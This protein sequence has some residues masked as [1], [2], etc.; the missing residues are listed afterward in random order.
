MARKLG[1]ILQDKVL[2]IAEEIRKEAIYAPLEGERVG[3]VFPVYGW[4]PPRIVL[5]F[6]RK[7]QMQVL[8]RFPAHRADTRCDQK[9]ESVPYLFC[10]LCS[11]KLSNL[12]LIG[13]GSGSTKTADRECGNASCIS[14][15]LGQG[16]TLGQALADT[17]DKAVAGAGGIHSLD[18]ECGHML[19]NAV[20]TVDTTLYTKGDD[21]VLHTQIVHLQDG[22]LGVFDGVQLHAEDQLCLGLIGDHD[23]CISAQLFGGLGIDAVQLERNSSWGSAFDAF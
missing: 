19:C 23:I 10:F 4:E 5:D 7:M 15:A 1:D 14:K 11:D 22:V 21:G 6:I 18:N 3:F 20:L 8:G 13:E 12:C 17:A 2:S 16:L 9:N